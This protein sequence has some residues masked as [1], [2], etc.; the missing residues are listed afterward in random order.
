MGCYFVIYQSSFHRDRILPVQV[1]LQG[2]AIVWL[3]YSMN[4]TEPEQKREAAK[5]VTRL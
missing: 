2:F 3:K 5:W 1:K 4:I